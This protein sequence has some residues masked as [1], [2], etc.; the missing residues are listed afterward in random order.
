MEKETFKESLQHGTTAFPIAVYPMKFPKDQQVLAHLHYHNEF[1]LLVATKGHL[2]VQMETETYS[3]SAGEGLF[4]N[5]G[6]LHTIISASPQEETGFIAV[7]FDYSILCTEQDITYENYIRPLLN[8]SLEPNSVLSPDIC[9][10]I[11]SLF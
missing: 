6:T 7:V 3:L 2:L 8:G 10:L 5:S 1:E 11:H 4:I 9:T